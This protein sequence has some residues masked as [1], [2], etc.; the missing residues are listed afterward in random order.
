MLTANPANNSQNVQ[1]VAP[2]E[3]THLV[4]TSPA[5]ARSHRADSKDA[6]HSYMAD[7]IQLERPVLTSAEESELA[8]RAASGDLRARS[9]LIESSLWL[10]IAIARRYKSPGVPLIDLIQEGNLAL[11][12][13]VQKFDYLRGF[14]FSTY[15]VWW[16][17]RAIRR[18]VI[19]QTN[20]IRLPEEVAT[21]LR[22]VHRI[23]AQLTQELAADPPP[24]QVAAASH[25]QL[26]EVLELLG[27]V[28]QPE[29]L[30]ALPQE[31]AHPLAEAIEDHTT[32]PPDEVVT[33]CLL[34]EA[35]QR[36]MVRLTRNERQVISLRY[37]INNGQSLSLRQVGKVLG[38]SAERVRQLEGVALEKLRKSSFAQHET[39]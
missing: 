24:E 14:R 21:H 23:A 17:R 29:S 38:I 10:V 27:T 19:E 4:P 15:A 32:P 2:T 36:A 18:A 28:G 3:L 13:A 34:V 16:V 6:L 12:H 30:D 33:Q 8:Q 5:S 35:L 37:G 20:L 1:P 39:S 7:L 11:L 22:K 25:L 9:H 26:R 31:Q